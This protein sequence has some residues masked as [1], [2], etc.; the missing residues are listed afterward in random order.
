MIQQWFGFD[1]KFNGESSLLL[2]LGSVIYLYG[3]MPFLRGMV[4]EIKCS[5]IGM[6]KLVTLAISVVYFYS[7]AIVLLLQVF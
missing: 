2:L 6:M 7:V 1:L 3:G 5:N 4:G